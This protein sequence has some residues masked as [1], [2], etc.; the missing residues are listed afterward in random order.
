MPGP[1]KIPKK[2]QKQIVKN[3]AV[4]FDVAY[5]CAEYLQQLGGFYEEYDSTPDLELGLLVGLCAK[6]TPDEFFVRFENEILNP[7][8]EDEEE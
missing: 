7:P 3:W 1:K 4:P 6:G 8:D 5:A 2:L